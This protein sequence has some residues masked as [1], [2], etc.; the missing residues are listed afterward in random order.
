[1]R[2]AVK[3]MLPAVAII[4]FCSSRFVEPKEAWAPAPSL[5]DIIEDVRVEHRLP[6]GLI[7]SV[8]MQESGFQADVVR[9]EP[10]LRKKFA[11]KE[12]RSAYGLMQVVYGWHKKRCGLSSP[13]ELL[14]PSVNVR[15][16]AL[17]LSERYDE[18]V[19]QTLSRYNGSEKYGRDVLKQW[20]NW[21]S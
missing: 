9:E 17:V 20:K 15:C 19:Q 5:A 18:A 21:R 13:D 4:G 12:D 3:A 10:T 8:I 1:M 16:G 11:K 7:E 6:H 2:R 14:I